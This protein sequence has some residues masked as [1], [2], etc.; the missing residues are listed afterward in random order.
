MIEIMTQ[1]GKMIAYTEIEMMFLVLTCIFTGI[2]IGWI[3]TSSY[4]E[5][6]KERQNEEKYLATLDEKQR[7][8]Y[9]KIIKG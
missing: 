6:K 7:E 4:Y 1:L 8:K 3:L 5:A 9:R 2:M